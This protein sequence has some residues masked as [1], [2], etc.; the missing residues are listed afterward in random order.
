MFSGLGWPQVDF[1]V[2]MMSFGPIY[3]DHIGIAAMDLDDASAFWN[4]I[5][6]KQG[7]ED[8]AVEDQGV[9]TRFFSTSPATPESMSKPTL[10]ELLEPTGE[11]T[12]IGRFLAKKGPG[13]QQICF[14]VGDLEGLIAHL[15]AN[16]IVMIDEGPRMGAGGKRIAFVHPK[17][18]GGVLV[19]LT[20]NPR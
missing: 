16:G 5:G 11:D 10:V 15:L 12:P 13:V 8:E 18:T 17:S 9:T 20:E 7:V 4:L 14:R 6:L 1:E 3:I 2:M 19:E